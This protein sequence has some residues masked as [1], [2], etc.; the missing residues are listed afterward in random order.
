[1]FKVGAQLQKDKTEIL[2]VEQDKGTNVM[3]AG[4]CASSI[5]RNVRGFSIVDFFAVH[6]AE[7]VRNEDDVIDEI[8]RIFRIAYNDQSQKCGGDGNYVKLAKG[9]VVQP[10][11]VNLQM[12]A[13]Q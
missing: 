5:G 4:C 12:N 7:N 6:P 8:R 2:T 10:A 9:S 11:F 3:M 1:M 13:H